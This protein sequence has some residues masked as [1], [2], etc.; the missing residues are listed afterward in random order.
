[1]VELKRPRW[2]KSYPNA[3]LQYLLREE[4]ILKPAREKLAALKDNRKPKAL[5]LNWKGEE[6]TIFDKTLIKIPVS[7]RIYI[8]QWEEDKEYY[9]KNKRIVPHMYRRSVWK[10]FL[11]HIAF[12]VL[13]LAL[14]CFLAL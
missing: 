4:E 3:W 12:R 8:S 2:A 9:S 5:D 1:M 11:Q 7:D 6:K 13:P 14:I 10:P